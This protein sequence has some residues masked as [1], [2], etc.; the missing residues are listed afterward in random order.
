M[1]EL[2]QL[3]SAQEGRDWRTTYGEGGQRRRREVAMQSD[4]CS[5]E[6]TQSRIDGVESI[7]P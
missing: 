5:A 1:G 3:G 6:H 7:G 2:T 4:G